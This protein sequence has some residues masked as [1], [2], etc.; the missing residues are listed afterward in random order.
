LSVPPGDD[1]RPTKDR[2]REAVFSALDARDAIVDASVLDLYAGTGALAVEALSRGASRAVLVEQSRAIAA[3]ARLNVDTTGFAGVARVET[4]DV[5]GFLGAPPREAPFDLVL[6]DPPYDLDD[7][8]LGRV[9]ARVA[10]EGWLATDA[11][12]VVERA[13]RA[14]IVVPAGLRMTWERRFGDTLVVFLEP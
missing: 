13:P 8:S 3:T 1:V 11:Y 14:S 9:L 12:V 5:A 2:V 7:E 6:C 10:G 4:R